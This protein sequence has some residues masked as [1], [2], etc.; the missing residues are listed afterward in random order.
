VTYAP[1]LFDRPAHS[2]ERYLWLAAI[3]GDLFAACALA[4]KSASNGSAIQTEEQEEIRA[5][6]LGLRGRE[7][8]E[9]VAELAGVS[10]EMIITKAR[11]LRD[12][13]WSRRPLPDDRTVPIRLSPTPTTYR[14]K[15]APCRHHR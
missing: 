10:A 3:K 2:P 4:R 7:S 1:H 5:W 8:L 6:L 15:D 11:E 14:A 13:G 12:G 9:W